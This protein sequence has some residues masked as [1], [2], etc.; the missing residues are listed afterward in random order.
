MDKEL[1]RSL[2]SSLQANITD[3]EKVYGGDINETFILYSDT[4]KTFLKLNTGDKGDMFEK[5][6]KGLEILKNANAITGPGPIV[7]GKWKDH[8]YL[9][10]ECIEKGKASPDFWQI[11][12]RQLAA[13]HKNTSDRFGLDH[14]NYIGSLSQQNKYS[15]SWGEFYAENRVLFL[16]K[17]AYD[18][19]KCDG[20][21]ARMAERLCNKM[22]SLF[23]NEKPSLLHGDLWSGNFMINNEGLPVIYDP[24]VYYGHREMDIGMSLLFGGFDKSFYSFYNEALPMEKNW[25]QRTDLTQLYPLLVH[26]ILF[27]GHYYHPVRDILKKYS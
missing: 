4:K 11:F 8:I 26:L 27:G 7:T 22:G 5:E 19:N 16:I 3:T 20:N 13:L 18:E 1:L 12:G 23:P 15:N 24:A 17:K 25:Q 2:E 14:D 9:L 10:M 6:Y 21:D